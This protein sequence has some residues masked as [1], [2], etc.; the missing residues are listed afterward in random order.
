M[1]LYKGWTVSSSLNFNANVEIDDKLKQ[2]SAVTDEPRDAVLHTHGVVNR[3]GRS[4]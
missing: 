4:V 3:G 2:V 1:F